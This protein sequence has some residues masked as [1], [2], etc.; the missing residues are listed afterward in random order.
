MP[1]NTRCL[2]DCSDGTLL[3]PCCRWLHEIGP[4]PRARRPGG[5][6]PGRA[7]RT[8]AGTRRGA[9]PSRRGRREPA[10]RAAAARALPAAARRV[11]GARARRGGRHRPRCAGRGLAAAGRSRLCAGQWRRLCRVL[12]RALSA[13]HADPEGLR[14]R[15]GRRPA[16]GV[17]H[18]VEQHGLA[19][20]PRPWR[21]RA[22][23]RR[24]KWRR[25]GGDPDRTYAARRARAGDRR[26]RGE[27]PDLPGN[28]GPGGH[29]LPDLGLGSGGAT[30][31]R[32]PRRRCRSRRSGRR[33]YR[34]R[35][36]FAEG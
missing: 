3:R 6:E 32:R 7:R 10:R 21:D 12:Q 36:R 24:H 30:A 35:A 33:L 9:D 13:V 29:Q 23:A 4:Y 1:T 27:V 16:G 2:R 17:L 22:G 18:C 15:R 19:G 26:H 5:T 25:H 14:F 8:L 20:P 28:R 34:A 31:D 11:R